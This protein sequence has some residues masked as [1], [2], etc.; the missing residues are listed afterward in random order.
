MTKK[1]IATFSIN[2]ELQLPLGEHIDGRTPLSGFAIH[3]GLF[4]DI[5]EV[6]RSELSNAA[7]TIAGAQMRIDH[8]QSVRDVVGLVETANVQFDSNAQKDGVFFDSFIEDEQVSDKVAKGFVT[9]VSIGFDFDPE[10]S[11]CGKNFRECEHWFDEAH[12]IAKNVNVF[13]LSLVTRGADPDAYVTATSFTEQF[14]DKLK[15]SLEKKGG[16]VME[17]KQHDNPVDINGIVDK[18]SAAEK[19][20]LAKAQEAEKLQKELEALKAEKEAVESEKEKLQIEKEALKTEKEDFEG[21]FKDASD[22]LTGKE[23]AEKEA[24]VMGIIE[25]EISKELLKEEEVDA[26][27][28]K[29]MELNDAGLETAKAYVTEFQKPQKEIPK[30][31]K[32]TEFGKNMKEKQELDFEDKRVQQGFIHDIFRYDRVFKGKEGKVEGRDYM[33]FSLEE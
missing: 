21:K 10:C 33:G 30:V 15:N 2:N 3:E 27:K 6:P 28:E 16:S 23:L 4:K 9:D 31:P 25:E 26:R 18:L 12:I 13:E 32:T 24:V 11:E 19:E 29:L 20:A 22:K 1:D 5:V 8:S 17:D 14:S 7:K